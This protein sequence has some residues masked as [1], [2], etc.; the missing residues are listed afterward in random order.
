MIDLKSSIPQKY[1][2][3]KSKMMFTELSN[4]FDTSKFYLN[5]SLSPKFSA[6]TQKNKKIKI[7]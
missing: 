6:E 7:S 1:F 5:T 4:K 2:T 3:L